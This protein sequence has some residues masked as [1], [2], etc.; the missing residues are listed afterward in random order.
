M[1][2]FIEGQGHLKQMDW[3]L[4]IYDYDTSKYDTV[5]N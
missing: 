4:H 5:V 3:N 2:S 1:Q